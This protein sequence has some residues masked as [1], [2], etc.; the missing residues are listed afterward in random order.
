MKA[1]TA[2]CAQIAI[3]PNAV[4]EN[5]QKIEVWL[6]QAVREHNADLVVF[7]ETVTTGW[8]PAMSAEELWELVDDIPGATTE[9]IARAARTLGVHVVLPTYE[10]GPEQGTVYN[11][12]AIIDPHGEV[13]GVYR[14]THLFPTERIMSGGWSTPGCE[15]PVF[16]TELGTMGI[17][18]CYDGDF[19]ELSRVMAIKGAELIVRPS[20]LLRSFEIWD[21]TNRARAYDNHLYVVAANAVGPDAGGN[22]FFGH[23]QIISPIA[24]VLAQARGT[25]EIISTELDPEPLKYMTYG[26]KSP[27]VFNHLEDRN[28]EVYADILKP[29]KSAF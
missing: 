1:F 24:R 4:H 7:P 17:I 21:V 8:S 13:L 22:Y 16:K 10:R 5:L 28:L 23:S 14:K 2:A 6:E 11:S 26:A 20:A 12:A 29:A 3:P 25:E 19:P 18:I 9:P 27:M 15:A